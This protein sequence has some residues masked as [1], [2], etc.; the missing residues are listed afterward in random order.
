MTLRGVIRHGG[1]VCILIFGIALV[2]YMVW[3]IVDTGHWNT[4]GAGF[5]GLLAIALGWTTLFPNT[6]EPIAV[7]PD[8]PFM[9]VAVER[10]RSTL[11]R[12]IEGVREGRK[13]AMVKFPLVGAGGEVEQV[14]G[15][16]HSLA[17]ETATVSLVS[18]PID[19]PEGLEPRQP[20]ALADVIDWMLVAG[21]GT[22]EG[23]FSHLAMLQVYKREKGTLPRGVKKDFE[24]FKDLRLEDL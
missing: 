9:T 13:H 3:S 16:V 1:G 11:P 10:A 8:D 23:G 24:S 21:D 20:V 2:V 7:D 14:W 17:D 15:V 19:A 6:W 22:T 18:E 12:L 4:L 5:F